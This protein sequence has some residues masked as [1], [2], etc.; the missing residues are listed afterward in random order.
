[1]KLFLEMDRMTFGDVGNKERVDSCVSELI[2]GNSAEICKCPS[3]GS[4]THNSET[5]RV[6]AK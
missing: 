2:R 4:Q 6:A 1:M 5:D 3:H